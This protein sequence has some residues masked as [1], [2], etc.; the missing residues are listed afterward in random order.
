M[1]TNPHL[2][3][4]VRSPQILSAVQGMPCEMRIASFIPG[5]RCAHA[6]TVVAAH[7]GSV[8]KGM[9]TKVSDHA[10]CAACLHC[11]DLYDRRDSRWEYLADTHPT[12]VMQRV[13][14]GT[15]ATQARLFQLGHIIVP[16]GELV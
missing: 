9:S 14:L 15:I 2:L 3:P 8:G 16:K 13:L 10:I 11:H 7:V 5:H 1:I 12:A 4:K 6:S